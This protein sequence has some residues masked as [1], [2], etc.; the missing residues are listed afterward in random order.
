MSEFNSSGKEVHT[1]GDM[2]LP[3]KDVANEYIDGGLSIFR[4]IT[5]AANY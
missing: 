4:Q 3:P 1:G 2:S 5:I